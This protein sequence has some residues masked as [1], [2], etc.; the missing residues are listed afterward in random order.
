LP[1]NKSHLTRRHAIAALGI[2]AFSLRAAPSFAKATLGDDGIYHMDWY[3]ELP[4]SVRGS[5]RRDREGQ[6]LCNHVG[7]ERLPGL[8]ADA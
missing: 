1:N 2:G 6:A 5:R 3:L 4:R 8:Q 7:P